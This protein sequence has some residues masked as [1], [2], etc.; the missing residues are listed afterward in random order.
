MTS[1]TFVQAALVKTEKGA[2][3]ALKEG[4]RKTRE[5]DDDEGPTDEWRTKLEAA[6][7]RAQK[8]TK[9]TIS[10]AD[11]STT[12]GL[13][14]RLRIGGAEHGVYNVDLREAHTMH[15]SA[16]LKEKED[17][18][19]FVGAGAGAGAGAGSSSSAMATDDDFWYE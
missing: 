10:K 18:V 9:D 3:K 14:V 1:A 13:K 8:W 2:R 15:A 19:M 11:P 5:E 17:E 4:K 16:T 7:L 6:R 12:R